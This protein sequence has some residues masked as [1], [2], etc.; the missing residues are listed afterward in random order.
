MWTPQKPPGLIRHGRD[1]LL[2]PAGN[3]QA[4]QL[5]VQLLVRQPSFMREL[6][7]RAQRKVVAAYQLAEEIDAIRRVYKAKISSI[8]RPN[9]TT[10]DFSQ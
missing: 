3:A 9:S 6:G 10:A 7:N 4:L 2:V 5:A 1:G 8:Q